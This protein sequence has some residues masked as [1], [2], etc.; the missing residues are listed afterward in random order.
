MDDHSFL[1]LFCPTFNFL[2]LDLLGLAF[3]FLPFSNL[4]ELFDIW[5]VLCVIGSS[6]LSP[7]HNEVHFSLLVGQSLCCCSDVHRVEGQKEGSSPLF[8]ISSKEQ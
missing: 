7:Q 1:L 3:Y 8:G 6:K 4:L 5:K 2:L